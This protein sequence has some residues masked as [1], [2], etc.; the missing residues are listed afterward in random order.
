MKLGA[1][2][3]V[4]LCFVASDLVQAQPEPRLAFIATN[5][6]YARELAP[7]QFPHSDGENVSAALKTLGFQVRTLRD[8]SRAQFESELRAFLSDLR[9]AGRGAVAFFYFSGHT[10]HDG[11]GKNYF[12]LNEKPPGGDLRDLDAIGIP[13][14]RLTHSLRA[15]PNRASFVVIDSHL[16]TDE[17]ALL[18]GNTALMLL[19][20]GRPGLQAADN[21]DF[22]K[23]LAKGLLTPGLDALAMFK[24]VQVELTELTNGKQVPWIGDRL[25]APYYF[26]PHRA[27]S[28]QPAE[29]ALG[30][31]VALVI[32]NS[33]YRHAGLLA[34]PENDARAIA[35]AL[36]QLGFAEV[37]DHYNLDRQSL[38]AAL[39]QFGAAAENADWAVV[40]YAGHGL[41]IGGKNYLVP[42]DAKL[43]KEEDAEDEA[44]PVARL[45]DR[46][47]GAKA[48][49][50]VILDACRDNRLAARSAQ[51]GARRN[52]TIGRGLAKMDAES[53]TLIALAADPGMPAF[54]GTGPHS[55]YASALLRHIAEPG[56]EVRLMFGRVYDT[57][58]EEMQGQQEPWIQAKL[59]GRQYFFRPQ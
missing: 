46:I 50:I 40:Y 11:K 41:E 3:I 31:R 12:I 37:Q 14:I 44:V 7:L 47:A 56:L 51:R 43:E 18:E 8:G 36:R 25:R 45:F 33:R 24:Q 29:K 10:W 55:P 53:G 39:R 42:V 17:P 38:I 59:G 15:V 23:A 28:A 54:D 27:A 4:L 32:G 48:L 49:K 52:L 20:R 16:E 13:F 1:G 35:R 21:N 6:A 26:Q 57:M 5:Q 19:T 9:S 34:N 22:S 58:R 30:R 2:L